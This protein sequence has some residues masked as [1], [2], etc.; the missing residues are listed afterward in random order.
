[1]LPLITQEIMEKKKIKKTESIKY[2]G[3]GS[4]GQESITVTLFEILAQAMML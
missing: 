1:M 2:E 4:H 3:F